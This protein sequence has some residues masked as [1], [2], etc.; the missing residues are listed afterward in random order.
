MKRFMMTII[1]GIF[2]AAAIIGILYYTAV[3]LT[4]LAFIAIALIF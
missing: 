3:C 1:Q 4:V 2:A